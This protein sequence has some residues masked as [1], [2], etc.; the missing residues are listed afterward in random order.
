MY[1]IHVLLP[2]H[3]NEKRPLPVERFNAVRTELTHQFGGVTAF[4]RAPATGLWEQGEGINRDEIVTFEIL[5]ENIDKDWWRA[6]RIELQQVFKQKEILIWAAHV[7][8]L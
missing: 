8:K 4:L 2:I 5:A 1:L 6:Y 7:D 3:D